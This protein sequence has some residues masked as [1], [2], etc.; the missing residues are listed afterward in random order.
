MH[1]SV[2]FTATVKKTPAPAII[3]NGREKPGRSA[4]FGID[5]AAAKKQCPEPVRALFFVSV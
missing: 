4:G 1:I 2:F 5:R 3:G